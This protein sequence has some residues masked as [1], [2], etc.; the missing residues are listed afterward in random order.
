MS[1]HNELNKKVAEAIREV[2]ENAIWNVIA[3]KRIDDVTFDAMYNP[4]QNAITGV[5]FMATI[6]AIWDV[7]WDA[8]R[9][10]AYEHTV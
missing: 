2:T 9:N 8:T 1:K 6:N 4:T 10:A 3:K 7:T 5:G